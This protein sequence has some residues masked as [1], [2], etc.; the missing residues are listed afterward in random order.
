MAQCFSSDTGTF[1]FPSDRVQIGFANRIWSYAG[2]MVIPNAGTSHD[3]DLATPAKSQ[4]IRDRHALERLLGFIIPKGADRAA[5][6]LLDKYR[7]LSRVI[8]SFEEYREGDPIGSFLNAARDCL[9]NALRSEIEDNPIFSATAAV[10]D[11][12]SFTMAELTVEQIRVLFLN[13]EN[14]LIRD[15][16]V[17]RGTINQAPIY[18]REIIGRALEY[19]STALILAHNHP[20]GDPQP[21][22]YDVEATKRL[23][24]ACN[25]VGIALHDHIIVARGGWVSLKSEGII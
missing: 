14:R 19:G 12:L 24:F 13:S 6:H 2:D 11:Y 21:S 18:N 17:S 22:K 23:R 20:S 16:I 9:A 25:E 1:A 3:R 5:K 4:A 10:V 8:S 7:T 15:E